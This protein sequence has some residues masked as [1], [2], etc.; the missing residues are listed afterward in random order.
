MILVLQIVGFIGVITGYIFA[1]MVLKEVIDSAYNGEWF[2]ASALLFMDIFLVFLLAF[3]IALL[4]GNQEFLEF[5][6]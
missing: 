1:G 4:T 6:K 5:I 3:M 2:M